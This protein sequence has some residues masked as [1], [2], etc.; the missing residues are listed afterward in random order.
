MLEEP[1]PYCE[2]SIP[3]GCYELEWVKAEPRAGLKSDGQPR[4]WLVLT[5]GKGLGEALVQ[6]LQARGDRTVTAAWGK[7]FARLDAQRFVLDPAHRAGFE[8][9][10]AE[11]APEGP[12]AG[13]V[14]LWSVDAPDN[15]TLD[16]ASLREAQV[17]GC[18]SV[19]HLVQ[20]LGATDG[21]VKPGILLVTEQAQPVGD[22]PIQVAQSPVLGIGKGI[23]MENPELWGGMVD[24]PAG[25]VEAKVAAVLSELG[26]SG[27]ETHVAYR[28]SQ[29][30]VQRLVRR[31]RP[32]PGR[33]EVRTEATYVV[34]GGTGGLGLAATRWLADL[35]ARHILLT[36]RRG[37]NEAS[38]RD[39]QVLE[40][41]GVE[42]RVAAVDVTDEGAMRDVFADV[43]RSMPPVRGVIHAAGRFG[44]TVLSEQSWD[45][46]NEILDAK[47]AGTFIVHEL[48]KELPLDFF[49]SYSSASAVIGSHG[50]SAY[51]AANAFQDAL[52][53]HRVR[54]GLP[55][56]AVNWGSWAEVG[57]AQALPESSRRAL[58][59]RG[60]GEIAPAE[61]VEVLGR[62]IAEGRPQAV[63]MQINWPKF[64]KGVVEGQVPPYFNRVAKAAAQN[65]AAATEG[66]GIKAQVWAAS[67]AERLGILR[68]YVQERVATIL[69]YANAAQ[70]D[71][72]VTLL[73]LGF[74]SLMAVQLRNQIRTQL[75]ID[76]PVGK[77]FDSTSV[78]GMTDLLRERLAAGIVSE[79]GLG[80][81]VVEVI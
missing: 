16:L 17:R 8:R 39:I 42:V 24:V 7:S 56:L 28:G 25:P 26:D 20:A 36:S 76:V 35:G 67:P 77:L 50:Q 73:E 45:R 74:D 65:V 57:V 9:L 38:L 79:R 54:S 61:G 49:V 44:G 12:F 52:S 29:R 75:E 64:V 41:R 53:H 21:L 43:A 4:R 68:R 37:G 19:I 63:V 3:H 13:V 80:E 23:W 59:D 15:A 58:R 69:G 6:R 70:V 60:M 78:E 2:V 51:V 31:P 11:T 47:V 33:P 22:G 71:R 48:T 32:E 34:T 55:G 30:F 27:G 81:Q 72:D 10:L 40:S 14:H 1:V 5:D 18:A 66:A 46:F 62:L